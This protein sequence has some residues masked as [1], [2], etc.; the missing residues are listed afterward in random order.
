MEIAVAE[1]KISSSNDLFAEKS[2]KHSVYGQIW[3]KNNM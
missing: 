1:L 3:L 2:Q